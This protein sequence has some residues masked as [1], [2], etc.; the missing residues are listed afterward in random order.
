MH[1]VECILTVVGSHPMKIYLVRHSQ[2]LSPEIDPK[3][4]LSP[5]GLNQIE[6]LGKFLASHSFPLSEVLHSEKLRAKQTA[7]VLGRYLEPSLQI[8]EYEH[9]NPSDPI[10]P[11]FEKL[12]DGV[13]IV[14]HLPYLQKLSGHLV[15]HDQNAMVI[16]FCCAM[17][18]CLEKLNGR[19]TI[20]WAIEPKFIT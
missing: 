12:E 16:N 1:L 5:D 7:E 3:S 11:I 15:T 14:G 20:N 6:K 9:L 18:V 19:F 10:E 17:V 2:A 8:K 4:P 13:M